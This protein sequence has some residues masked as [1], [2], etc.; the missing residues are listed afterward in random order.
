MNNINIGGYGDIADYV[1]NL[2]Y[3][4]YHVNRRT[5]EYYLL[6]RDTDV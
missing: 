5:Q 3:K 4:A 6:L 1:I 2:D